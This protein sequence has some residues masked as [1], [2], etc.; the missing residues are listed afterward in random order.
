MRNEIIAAAVPPPSIPPITFHWTSNY[1][2]NEGGGRDA[3]ILQIC[4]NSFNHCTAI[5]SSFNCR[6]GMVRVLLFDSIFPSGGNVLI[7]RTLNRKLRLSVI[8][9]HQNRL[10]VSGNHSHVQ[11]SC[12][13]SLV[14]MGTFI[15]H[16]DS[17][18]SF[19]P[20]LLPPLFQNTCMDV[21]TPIQLGGG[22]EEGGGGG[23]VGV[24]SC[25]VNSS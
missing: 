3:P 8:F 24:S 19:P 22:V 21:R 20:L 11:H 25:S 12:I 5:A 15:I 9:V 13:N 18:R 6:R 2:S 4:S 16:T 23:A 7:F 10:G 14:P 17:P 1:F